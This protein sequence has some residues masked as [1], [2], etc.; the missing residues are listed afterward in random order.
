MFIQSC[1]CS[2][3]FFIMS[4]NRVHSTWTSAP[5][6]SACIYKDCLFQSYWYDGTLQMAFTLHWSQGI[7]GKEW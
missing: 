2:I 6:V 7:M 1:L 3:C 4:G 5:G